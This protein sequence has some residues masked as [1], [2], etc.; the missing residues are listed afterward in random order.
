MTYVNFYRT[1]EDFAAL[2]NL[3][4]V[5]HPH[6]PEKVGKKIIFIAVKL[7]YCML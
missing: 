4:Q 6:L 3:L 2:L 1:W 5:T 7:G